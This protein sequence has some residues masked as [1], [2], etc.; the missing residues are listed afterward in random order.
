MAKAKAVQKMVWVFSGC[1]GECAAD[2]ATVMASE[3]EEGLVIKVRETFFGPEGL[4]SLED[5]PEDDDD[6]WQ[7]LANAGWRW[8]FHQVPL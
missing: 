6:M 7:E 2:E 4:G 1:D 3:T 5:A 8:V